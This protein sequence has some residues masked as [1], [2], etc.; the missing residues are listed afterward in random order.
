MIEHGWP[1]ISGGPAKWEAIGKSMEI[2]GITAVPVFWGFC[3]ALAETGGG[4]LMALGLF[5]RPAVLAIIFTMLIAVLI[6]T[7]E[8]DSFGDW[9]EAA[10]V[11]VTCIGLFVA[12]PGKYA[13][14]LR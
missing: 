4:L 10:E 9:A 12:G 1:K 5:Y 11:G 8:G 14:R 13:L 6:N 2:L 3:A 7:R